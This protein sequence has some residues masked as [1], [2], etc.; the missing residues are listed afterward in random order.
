MIENLNAALALLNPPMSVAEQFG[1]A[2]FGKYQFHFFG[3]WAVLAIWWHYDHNVDLRVP[4]IFSVIVP[5]TE[6]LKQSPEFTFGFW[7]DW[8]TWMWELH[9]GCW[10]LTVLVFIP[11]A[12]NGLYIICKFLEPYLPTRAPHVELSLDDQRNWDVCLIIFAIFV[13]FLVA[14]GPLIS[15]LL[16]IAFMLAYTIGIAEQVHA[17]DPK[18]AA[19]AVTP[20]KG[21]KGSVIIS[22]STVVGK[23]W[24][25]HMVGKNLDEK[26]DLAVF[27][28]SCIGQPAL[29]RNNQILSLFK[30]KL[31]KAGYIVN[32]SRAAVNQ[33]DAP[34]ST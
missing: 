17:Y 13:V 34:K 22:D 29:F 2:T 30:A 12:V 18:A 10:W 19:A 1:P 33:V 11:F 5:L 21:G 16:F 8:V 27:T 31:E 14:S 7:S 20:A 25:T 26:M 24:V 9:A 23:F 6:A 32:D 3:M 15:S 28:K 4:V